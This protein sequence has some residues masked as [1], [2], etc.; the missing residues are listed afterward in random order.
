[1]TPLN[2][3]L[4]EDEPGIREGL[5]SY[6]QL[7][8]YRVAT[9][10]SCEEGLAR[11][12]EEDFDIV[13]TD[14]HLGDG[15]GEVI[16][17]AANC[18]ALVISGVTEQVELAGNPIEVIR[19]PVL[20]ADLV[21]K[22]ESMVGTAEEATSPRT[23][24]CLPADARDRLALIKALVR[25]RCELDDRRIEVH[26][27]GT[28]VHIHILLDQ[29]D[30]TLQASVMGIGGDVRCLNRQGRPLLEI[31]F[32]R[33]GRREEGHLIVGPMDEWPADALPIAVDFDSTER[34]PLRRIEELLELLAEARGSGRTAYLLN[35]PSW[36]RLHLEILGKAH[37]M[38]NREGAGP[39]LPEV[40]LELWR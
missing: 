32:F 24:D 21:K 14:W 1:M 19:K 37:A 6:L 29:D 16:A 11:I 22:I 30:E 31:R 4:V 38:P 9:A 12:A 33:D 10:G 40:L 25:D 36:I 17:I 20:P 2:L 7:K 8:G 18:P 34:F 5:A 13:V 35:V 23:V 39:H 26:D 27:D 28:F 3:L 15:L